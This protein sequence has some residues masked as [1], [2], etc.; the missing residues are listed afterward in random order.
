MNRCPQDAEEDWDERARQQG[1]D[2]VGTIPEDA[3]LRDMDRA[4]ESLL[5]LP[6]ESDAMRGILEALTR[7]AV[8]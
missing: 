5:G 1:L 4:G 2:L 3:K 7:L 8:A 6:A